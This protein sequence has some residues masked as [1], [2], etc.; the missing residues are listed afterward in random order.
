MTATSESSPESVKT[1]LYLFKLLHPCSILRPDKRLCYKCF[2]IANTHSNQILITRNSDY[3]RVF[4]FWK[5]ILN[6]LKTSFIRYL[7]SPSEMGRVSF[8]FFFFFWPFD[9][10]P[11]SLTPPAVLVPPLPVASLRFSSARTSLSSL[12]SVVA[13]F[14]IH[15]CI[16]QADKVNYNYCTDTIQQSPE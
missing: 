10:L 15:T 8:F 9:R 4:D 12:V 16:F 5:Q 1:E 11:V 6:T 13:I 7:G 3:Y 2:T 14:F